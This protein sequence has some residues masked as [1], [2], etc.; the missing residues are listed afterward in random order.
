MNKKSRDRVQIIKDF[1]KQLDGNSV[2]TFSSQ[3]AF[4]I[5]IAFFPFLMLVMTLIQFLPVSQK[6]LKDVLF[7]FIPAEM[8]NYVRTLMTEIHQEAS[9]TL[10][11]I[12]ALSTLWSASSGVY[13]LMRGINAVY[14]YPETRSY[15]KLKASSVVY[16]VFFII[17]IIATMGIFVFG[18][19]VNERIQEQFPLLSG[20]AAIVISLRAVVGMVVL[21]CFSLVMYMIVPNRRT[22]VRDEFIGAIVSAVGWMGFS[23][24]FSFYISNFANYSKFYGGITAIVLLMLWIYF[25][26]YI[27]L[28]GAQIN[29]FL[30]NNHR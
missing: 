27:M 26:M 7:S 2:D 12:T 21:F 14:R 25:C 30:K 1:I 11:S 4:F 28:L 22:R 8:G 17:I 9:G 19:V 15:V 20:T 29:V 6:E 5:V 23:Y 10:V 13:A 3:A 24:A 18:D 16:T